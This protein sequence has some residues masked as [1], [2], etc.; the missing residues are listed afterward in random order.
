LPEITTEEQDEGDDKS[1]VEDAADLI[2]KEQIRLAE[3]AE[4]KLRSRSQ[5]LQR[6]DLPRPFII[7]RTILKE[8]NATEENSLLEQADELMKVEMLNILSLDAFHYPILNY[9]K[10]KYPVDISEIEEFSFD[11]ISLAKVELE[12]RRRNRQER[13]WR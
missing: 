1:F 9:K 13:K 4:A 12:K 10:F 3:E 2:T 7:N 8:K 5:V 11:E 6:N